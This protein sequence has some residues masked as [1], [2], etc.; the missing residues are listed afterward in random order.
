MYYKNN[1]QVMGDCCRIQFII[2]VFFLIQL[3]NVKLLVISYINPVMKSNKLRGPISKTLVKVI[4][5]TSF[6]FILEL[7]ND[8]A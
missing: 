7:E 4:P 3:S 2:K 5:D 1:L 8:V 6:K